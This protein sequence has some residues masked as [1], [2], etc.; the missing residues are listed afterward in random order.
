M[1]L[2]FT[3]AALGAI[4]VLSAT[5]CPYGGRGNFQNRGYYNQQGYNAP[6]GNYADE[7]GYN[8]DNSRGYRDQQGY[9]DDSESYR[10]NRHP[11]Y[12][13]NQQ[14][15][16]DNRQN[17]YSNQD[18]MES[19]KYAFGSEASTQDAQMNMNAGQDAAANDA[20]K[21]LNS[22]IRERL[23]SA[24]IKGYETLVFRTNN[25]VVIISGAVDSPDDMQ[26]IN[27]KL[28]DIRGI[29]SL[30]NQVI[31]KQQQQRN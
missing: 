4:S 13:D 30:R 25:G 26:K 22:K 20:D 29:K 5:T 16:N 11:R 23:S 24:R 6:R 31:T 14:G 10:Q 27:E 12:W 18:Y 2:M 7:D 3:L 1:K 8:D 28:K 15:Y 21:Q 19:R 9:Y 17:R